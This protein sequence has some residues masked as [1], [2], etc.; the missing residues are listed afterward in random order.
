MSQVIQTTKAD[1]S[2]N[3]LFLNGHQL[4]LNDY[5][6]LRAIYNSDATESVYMFSRQTA[7]STTLSNL[8]ITNSVMYNYFKSLYIAPTVDQTKVFSHDRI[9]PVLEG[10]PLIKEHYMNSSLVQNV[11]MKQ[12][13]NGSR[14]YLRYALLNADRIRGYSADMNIFDEVQDLREDVIP[15]VQETM[16]RS[17]FKWTLYAGTPK[18]SK[19]TLA[20]IWDRSSK[21]EYILKC[22]S[23]NHWNIL[24]PDNIGEHGVVC[25][26]CGRSM[27]VKQ[28]G[29]W[30]STYSLTQ[31]PVVEGF[32][33]CLLHFD[34]APWVSWEKDVLGKQ[35]KY[36]TAKYYNEVLALE[37]DE[38]TSPITEADLI[39]SSRSEY[40]MTG[41]PTQLDASYNDAVMG[42][43]YGPIN[44]ENSHTVITIMQKRG[45]RY[46][47]LYMK[48]FLGK[49]ADY[50][51]I[52]KII[53]ELM[54]KWKVR[55]LAADYGMGEAPN[56]EIRS[57]IGYD[58]V[59]A[60]QHLPTQKEKIRWNPKMPAYTLSRNQVM[61]DFF[62]DI[63]GGKFVFP[64]WED[65]EPFKDDFL[66]VQMEFDE[67]KN[68]MK[69]ISIGPDDAVHSTLYCKVSL[70]LMY[71]IAN[72]S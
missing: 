40:V 64:R 9:N 72:F 55:H 10:S 47:V 7:K 31:K 43:D 8:M 52:H 24:G 62:Q 56:S 39:Q 15:V 67:E 36:S 33:V 22:Q 17:M 68:S 38:G 41:E 60:F 53:P 35:Q 66:N 63:K 19:G 23:C 2:E 12:L 27:N 44:S 1:F 32:R 26:K 37:Y 61:N 21:N 59:I 69:Y 29:Q 50:A 71:G 4:S 30:V 6:H 18:R 25:N 65:L 51:Y 28:G 13:L 34:K 16:S 57:R 14:M 11:F 20:N 3:F 5:P 48:K 46:H 42:I 70:D 54:D 45:D 58:K 49:E